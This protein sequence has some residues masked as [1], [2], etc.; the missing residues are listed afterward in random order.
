MRSMIGD[1]NTF[2]GKKH[3]DES[4]KKMSFS[5]CKDECIEWQ[6][7]IFFNDRLV[8]NSGVHYTRL[9]NVYVK[10]SV[11]GTLVFQVKIRRNRHISV[12]FLCRSCAHI[13][14]SS[15][16]K[17]L[18]KHNSETVRYIS[19]MTKKWTNNK[20][21]YA[22]IRKTMEDKGV[23][24]PVS[25]QTEWKQYKR[26]CWN[27]TLKNDLSVLDNYGLGLAIDHK[28]SV[29]EG[30]KNGVLPCIIGS[31]YNLQYVTASENSVKGTKCSITKEELC[32]YYYKS[33]R[34]WW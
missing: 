16:N 22:A 8:N 24:T 27:F 28:Y 25:A 14:C 20:K 7:D 3:S 32:E 26:S 4:L 9:K 1:G 30:Y 23:W 13:G 34:N 10:C 21:N 15:W 31:I 12:K 33:R 6:N 5:K 2:Y 29:L 17:G 18:T 11:C 19:E